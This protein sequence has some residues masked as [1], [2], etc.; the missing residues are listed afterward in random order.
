VHR[1]TYRTLIVVPV[2][3]YLLVLL[4]VALLVQPPALGWYGL[5][6]V[7]ALSLIL[8]TVALRLYPA[9]RV[10]AARV[11]PRRDAQP[12]LLVVADAHTSNEAFVRAVDSVCGGRPAEV[13]VVAPVLAD[14]L[15]FSTDDDAVLQ[16]D[17]RS[18]LHEALQALA[19]VGIEARGMIGS[20]DPLTAIGDALALFAAAEILVLA[21]EHDPHAWIED[22]LEAQV[23]DVYGIHSTFWKV[24][25]P[26]EARR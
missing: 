15:H 13:L 12:R 19:R 5:G 10:N 21:P 2:L 7:A 20:D 14:R 8:T 22:D 4:V 18:R 26:I 23:R 1:S 9:S 25:A 17:A 11:H 6:L 24:G 16:E 3:A